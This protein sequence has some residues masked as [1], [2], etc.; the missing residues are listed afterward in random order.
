M[1][2]IVCDARNRT[3][4]AAPIAAHPNVKHFRNRGMIWAFDVETPDAQFAQKFFLAGL[5]REILLRP[6]GKTVYFMPP[7]IIDDEQ[8]ALLTARTLEILNEIS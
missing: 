1:K 3:A 7:Y 5:K 8:A 4:L 6:I 2:Q